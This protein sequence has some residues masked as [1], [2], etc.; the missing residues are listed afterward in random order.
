MAVAASD[1]V[2]EGVK[3]GAPGTRPPPGWVAPEVM[4]AGEC[5]WYMGRSRDWVL[6]KCVTNKLKSSKGDGR[7]CMRM[8]RREWADEYIDRA[9]QRRS[10]LAR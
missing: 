6:D 1:T 5:A 10:D 9:R 8:I 3:P 4:D 2:A 7:T